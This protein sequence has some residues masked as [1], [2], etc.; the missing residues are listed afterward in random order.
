MFC[1]PKT[2]W[3]PTCTHYHDAQSGK[4][5]AKADQS[6]AGLRCGA[7]PQYAEDGEET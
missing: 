6:E 7:S 1:L 2:A 5:K 3:P 4:D